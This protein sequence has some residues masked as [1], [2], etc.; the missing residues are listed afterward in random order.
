M[1]IKVGCFKLPDDGSEVKTFQ[2]G[3]LIGSGLYRLEYDE[4]DFDESIS[5]L[6]RLMGTPTDVLGHATKAVTEVG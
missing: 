6:V 5:P 3:E 4:D 1:V 2:Q